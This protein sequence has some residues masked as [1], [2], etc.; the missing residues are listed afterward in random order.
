MDPFGKK[1]IKLQLN[2]QEEMEK[3]RLRM[4]MRNCVGIVKI[5]DTI[6]RILYGQYLEF[7]SMKNSE[8]N[9]YELQ[10]VANDQFFYL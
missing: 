4:R 5:N 8:H 10:L 3:L 2:W 6:Y 1:E 7:F 9:I